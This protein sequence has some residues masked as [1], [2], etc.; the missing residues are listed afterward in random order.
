MT[1]GNQ[2]EIDRARAQVRAAKNSKAAKVG[3]SQS[4]ALKMDQAEIMRE[5]QR[6]AELKKQGI[7]PDAD[8]AQPKKDY[9]T[10]FMKQ[11]EYDYGDEG[12][13]GDEEEKKEED[14]SA[15]HSA[16]SQSAAANQPKGKKNKKTK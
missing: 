3:N 15:S 6:R 11:Y 1:R 9:D 12:G 4:Q 16:A 7:D 14:D 13:D 8:A 5:K 10:S 2:R